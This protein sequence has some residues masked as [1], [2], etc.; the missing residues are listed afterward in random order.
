[1]AICGCCLSAHCCQPAVAVGVIYAD[2]WDELNTPLPCWLCLLRILLC[3][4]MLLQAL[5]FPLGEVTLHPLLRSACLFAVHMGSGSSPIS[6]GVFLPLPLLQPFPLLT[7]GCVLLLLLASVFV[8]SSNG[9]WVLAPLL[10]SFLLSPLASFPAPGCWVHAPTPAFTSLARPGLFIYS[11][12]K[13]FLSP[14]PLALR[15][16]H[17]LCCVSLFSYYLLLSFSFFPRWRLVCPGSYADLAQGCLWNYRVPL[18]SPCGSRLL[19]PSA[20]GDLE[21]YFIKR[22]FV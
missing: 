12:R 17:P 20:R 10:W 13:D 22:R 9:L 16:P 5:P 18:S 14:P 4:T 15:A 19:K 1:M 21:L 2:L 6:C 11:S 7:V 8:Y 3:V